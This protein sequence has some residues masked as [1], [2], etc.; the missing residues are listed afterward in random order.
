MILEVFSNPSDSILFNSTLIV[1]FFGGRWTVG[2]DD[3]RGLF[4][5]W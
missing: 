4:Q 2:L 5:P 1:A 3:I